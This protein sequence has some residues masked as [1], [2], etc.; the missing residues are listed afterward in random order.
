M[1]MCIDMYAD[2]NI[3]K[4]MNM[5]IDMRHGYRER[6]RRV[7]ANMC[8]DTRVD[9]CADM[10]VDERVDLCVIMCV[11][12]CVDTCVVMCVDMCI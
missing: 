6:Y 1:D 8:V 7:C 3:C 11:D 12:M 10:C 5:G 4:C 9:T 2:M